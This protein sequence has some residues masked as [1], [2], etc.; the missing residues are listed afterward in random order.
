MTEEEAELFRVTRYFDIVD[1]ILN[2]INKGFKES[3]FYALNKQDWE[4]LK[5]HIDAAILGG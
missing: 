4:I 5:E 3:D 2:K 1:T